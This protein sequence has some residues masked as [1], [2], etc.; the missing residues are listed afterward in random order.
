MMGMASDP[1]AAV[2]LMVNS[3]VSDAGSAAEIEVLLHEETVRVVAVP[4]ATGVAFTAQ[5]LHCVEPKSLPLRVIVEPELTMR[6]GALDS[7][8]TEKIDAA[9]LHRGDGKYPRASVM[10]PQ[11]MVPNDELMA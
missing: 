9:I 11:L 1:V 4:V 7:G 5:P 8:P 2:T 6:P 10:L 3:P